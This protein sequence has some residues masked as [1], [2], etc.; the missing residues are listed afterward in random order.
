[1][2]AVSYTYKYVMAAE[3]TFKKIHI[4]PMIRGYTMVQLVE[5]LRYKPE[6]HRFD[7]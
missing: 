3:S 5:E 4:A 6:G 1:M 7:S 2:S